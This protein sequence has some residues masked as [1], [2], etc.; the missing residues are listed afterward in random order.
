LETITFSTLNWDL[1]KKRKT[2]KE[3]VDI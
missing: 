1:M 3:G 2:I